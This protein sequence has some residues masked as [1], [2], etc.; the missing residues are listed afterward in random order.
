M[1]NLCGRFDGNISGMNL[2]VKNRLWHM[3]GTRWYRQM[4]ACLNHLKRLNCWIGVRK[5]CLKKAVSIEDIVR[6]EFGFLLNDF[7]IRKE[8]L[9]GVCNLEWASLENSSTL[10]PSIIVNT[11]SSKCS[12]EVSDFKS[13]LSSTFYQSVDGPKMYFQT[14]AVVMKEI[15]KAWADINLWGLA[16]V[17]FLCQESVLVSDLMH[18]QN[19]VNLRLCSCDEEDNLPQQSISVLKRLMVRVKAFVDASLSF[20]SFESVKLSPYQHLLWSFEGEQ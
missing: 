12:N 1:L 7:E 8:L 16:D 11:L 4:K 17:E 3:G 20:S 5:C 9:Q 6:N 13:A 2:F 19:H 14:G 15:M 18:L 10:E